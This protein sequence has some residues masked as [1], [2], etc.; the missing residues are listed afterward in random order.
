VRNSLGMGF[1]LFSLVACSSF[2]QSGKTPAVSDSQTESTSRSVA[3]VGGAAGLCP[4]VSAR[5]DELLRSFDSCNSRG[6]LNCNTFCE[7]AAPLLGG[8]GAGNGTGIPAGYVLES[9]VLQRINQDLNLTVRSQRPLESFGSGQNNCKQNVLSSPQAQQLV[10]DCNNRAFYIKRCRITELPG[11]TF[12]PLNS[13][14]QTFNGAAEK[15]HCGNR[16]EN[17]DCGRPLCEAEMNKKVAEYQNNCQRAYNARCD[18]VTNGAVIHTYNDGKFRCQQSVSITPY[19]QD[20]VSCKVM[21]EARNASI[22][23]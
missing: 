6:G 12:G 10:Q 1:L 7:G 2:Q 3:Q 22:T 16:P 14:T 8:G 21:L 15:K 23:E 9:S 11:A 18:V 5:F 19:I 17:T 13:V 4:R 20:G